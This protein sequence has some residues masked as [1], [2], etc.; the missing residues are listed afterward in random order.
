MRDAIADIVAAVDVPVTADLEAGYGDVERTV[1][2]ALAAGVAGV[3]LEDADL[4]AIL[5]A[6]G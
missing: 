5:R 6:R 1:G 3:N 2:E 4:A